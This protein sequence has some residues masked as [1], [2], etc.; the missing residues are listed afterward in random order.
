MSL[1]MHLLPDVCL[2]E[3]QQYQGNG[4]QFP[5]NTPTGKKRWGK[6]VLG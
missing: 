3:H 6:T 1:S 2:I 4:L 5:G